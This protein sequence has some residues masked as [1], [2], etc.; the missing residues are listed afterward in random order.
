VATGAPAAAEQTGAA[1]TSG[2]GP[3]FGVVVALAAFLFVGLLARRT[4]T[5]D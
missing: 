3:G 2:S 5:D 4:G 1:T